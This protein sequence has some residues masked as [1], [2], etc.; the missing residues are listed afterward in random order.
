M[1]RIVVTA[2]AVLASAAA[3]AVP[4]TPAAEAAPADVSR[5]FGGPGTGRIETSVALSRAAFPAG[6]P[7]VVVAFGFDFP[8]ALAAAP[9]ASAAGGPVL[10]NLRERLHGSVRE[11]VQ[12]LG[13]R[14]AFLMGGSAVQS[15]T[16]RSDLQAMGVEVERVDGPERMTTA[17]QAAR[18]AVDLWRSAGIPAGQRVL[19]ALGAHPDPSRAWPDALAAGGLAGHARWPLLLTDRDRV[20]EVTNATLRDLGA[21]HATVVGGTAAIPETTEGQLDAPRRDRIAGPNRFA[22]STALADVAV[23]H[24]ARRATVLAATGGNFPDGLAAGPTAV[25]LGGVLVL[26]GGEDLVDSADTKAWAEAHRGAIQRVRVA[27]GPAAVADEVLGQIGFALVDLAL[28]LHQVGSGF[29]FPTHVTGAPGDDRMYVAERAGRIRFLDG[30]VFLDI[31]GLVSSAGQEQGLLGLA[32]DPAYA[33]TGRYFVHYTD[34][35][36]DTVVAEYNRDGRTPRTLFR[37]DQ[38]AANHNGG[39]LEF[40]P[41]GALY[42]ALGDGGGSGDAYDNAQR[43]ETPLG[44][45]VR[46][47]PASGDWRTWMYGL[48]NP[49]RFSFDPPDGT[50]VI[51]DVGQSNYEEINVVAWDATGTNFGWP[52]RE[53]AHGFDPVRAGCPQSGLTDPVFEYPLNGTCAVIGGVVYRGSAIPELRGQYLYGDYC[54]GWIRGFHERHGSVTDERHWMDTTARVTSFGRDNAGEAYVTLTD[55][56]VRRLVRAS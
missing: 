49:Y 19:V 12:R 43:P 35:A 1:I 38:P 22:T 26:V 48:R 24:G 25:S 13:A 10:L 14:R 17:A 42:L 28:G 8:D 44:A 29:E 51:G 45:I 2:I 34:A 4:A 11:E 36:G 21:E 53:G 18:R 15:E 3:L 54:A 31:R 52:C 41:D 32:F 50:V 30:S 20:P 23:T 37:W 5:F 40:G 33:N 9:L 16:V 27:G 7:A 6:A 46:L 39:S 55:G 56:T 47:D